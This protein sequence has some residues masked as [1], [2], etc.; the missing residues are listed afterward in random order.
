[1][2]STE[3]LKY[4]EGGRGDKGNQKAN[5]REYNKDNINIKK[6]KKRI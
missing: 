2:M 3:E 6:I 4:W 1:M 5:E